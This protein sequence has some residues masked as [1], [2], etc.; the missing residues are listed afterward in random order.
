[1]CY[2]NALF[3]SPEPIIYEFIFSTGEIGGSNVNRDNAKVD[4]NNKADD[5][6][7]DK[8]KDDDSS[9]APGAFSGDNINIFGNGE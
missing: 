7:D 3:Y 2:L 9:V 8:K 1:V 5:N 6:Y 4:G